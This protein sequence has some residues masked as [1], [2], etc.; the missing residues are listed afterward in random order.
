MNKRNEFLLCVT[1][2]REV[3]EYMSKAERTIADYIIADPQRTR[4]LSTLELA[5]VTGT[6][7]ATISRFCRKIGFSGFAEFK[8]SLTK[9]LLS[10]NNDLLHL[11]EDDSVSIIKQTVLI[12]NKTV[13][14]GMLYTLDDEALK[15]AA[16]YLSA[17]N[18]VAII[19]DGSS[20]SSARNAYDVFLQLGI[21]CEYLTDPFFQIM[22]INQLEEG[23]VVFAVSNSG[24]SKNTIENLKLAKDKNLISIG[25][26]GLANSPISKYLDVVLETNIFKNEF[27][28][29]SVAAQICEVSTIAVL[30]SI[31]SL[32]NKNEKVLKD[33][34]LRDA[35]DA[36]RVKWNEKV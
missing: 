3:Y 36:K 7:P 17:A 2:M 14:E 9:E 4:N 16:D 11:T 23:D 33:K 8:T 15:R 24:R 32:H 19:G 27:F 28:C 26:I 6:S 34:A 18:R 5:A 20:G 22:A 12:F 30:Y 10:S 13:M 35:L 29:D 21:R 25:I 31:I 1:R